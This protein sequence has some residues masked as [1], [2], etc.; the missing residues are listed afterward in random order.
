MND[1]HRVRYPDPHDLSV[2]AL[3]T[4]CH[5][6]KDEVIVFFLTQRDAGI[7]LWY[8]DS[9][10]DLCNYCGVTLTQRFCTYRLQGGLR[11]IFNVLH[12]LASRSSVLTSA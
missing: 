11:W 8:Y 9:L 6:H 1:A 10:E 4:S 5:S 12:M 3:Y 7:H 2:D